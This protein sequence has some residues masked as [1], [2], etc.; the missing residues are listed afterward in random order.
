MAAVVKEPAPRIVSPVLLVLAGLCFLL[1]FAGV[2]CNTSA[3]T[4][5]LGSLSSISQQLGGQGSVSMP[6]GL[7]GCIT[8][9][10]NYNLATYSGLD[11]A[12]GSAPNAAGSAPS[13]CSALTKGSSSSIPTSADANQLGLGAQPLLL[14]AL[15]A[16]LLG[17]LLSLTRF[18]LRGLLVAVAAA[19]AI[20]LLVVEQGQVSTQV[21]D[22]ITHSALNSISGTFAVH[23]T[24]GV[25][26][27]LKVE[28]SNSFTIT[29]GVGFILAIVALGLTALYNLSAQLAP[30]LWRGARAGVA[31]PYEPMVPPAGDLP[32]PPPEAPPP[33]V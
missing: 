18:I 8:S 29:V 2:S 25:S 3:V 23:G 17:L 5:E 14:V 19:V 28:I 20:I 10:N 6:A 26:N 13:G 11:L 24:L 30:L 7:S 16:M 33:D 31:V 9:L 12:T 21:L 15:V 32:P 4:A 1:P 22:T 27:L